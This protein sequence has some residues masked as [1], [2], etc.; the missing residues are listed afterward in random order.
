[1][2]NN[3]KSDDP[4]ESG[5][6]GTILNWELGD[7]EDRIQLTEAVLEVNYTPSKSSF[8][9]NQIIKKLRKNILTYLLHR[10]IKVV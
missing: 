8:F 1:M 7:I 3:N 5:F 10:N 6:E 9:G 4:L 2:T